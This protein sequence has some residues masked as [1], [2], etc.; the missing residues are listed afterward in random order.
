MLVVS[1]VI[2]G[3]FSGLWFK[4]IQWA[5]GRVV[6]M[7]VVANVVLSVVIMTIYFSTKL[8]YMAMPFLFWTIWIVSQRT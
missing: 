8:S 7:S 6:L 3:A 1:A 5:Q 2:G 4:C